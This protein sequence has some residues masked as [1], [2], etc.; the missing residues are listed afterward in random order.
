MSSDIADDKKKGSLEGVVVAV[1]FDGTC[2]AHDFP[3]VGR[4]IG[5]P[6]V[7]RRMA[8]E[9]ARLILWTM[10][11][12]NRESATARNGEPME[13]PNPLTDAVEWFRDH[14]IPLF[15]IQRNPEQDE[16]TSSP[17]A[18]AGIYVDDAA[19]GC[20]LKPGRPGER[21][22]VDWDAVERILWPDYRTVAERQD[23][24]EPEEFYSPEEAVAFALSRE[25]PVAAIAGI[26]NSY[27]E[28]L[29][30]RFAANV[31]DVW[32]RAHDGPVPRLSSIPNDYSC[33]CCGTEGSL[34]VAVDCEYL[35]RWGD[36]I[37]KGEF[38]A[39]GKPEDQ[40]VRVLCDACGQ[41]LPITEG[42]AV[43]LRNSANTMT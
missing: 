43:M 41:H 29:N 16:W 9:G 14:D 13:N 31:L 19:I 35:E 40:P 39:L 33:P 28:V 20:P 32:A 3:R 42:L 7:L 6:R 34:D 18:Y 22:H 12:D 37:P 8:D 4:E 25:E 5:A 2:V 21:P 23:E 36:H 10:R 24:D 15:G 38:V 27:L 30:F 17:K 1:D 26:V 11:S